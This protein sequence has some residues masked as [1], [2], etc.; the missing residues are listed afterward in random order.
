MTK[1]NWH[2]DDWSWFPTVIITALFATI[3]RVELEASIWGFF[4]VWLWAMVMAV[5]IRKIYSCQN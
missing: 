4:L 5:I 2:V 1:K 3:V